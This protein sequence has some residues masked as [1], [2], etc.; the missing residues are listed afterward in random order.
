MK[1]TNHFN[2]A[3]EVVNAIVK[4]RYTVEGEAPSDYSVTDIINPI[5]VTILKKKYKDDLVQ[6]DVVDLFYSFLGSV[7]HQVLEDSTEG[8]DHTT[9][10]ERLYMKT[11]GVTISGKI[12]CYQ[13]ETKDRVAQIR[14]YKT[15]KVWNI[16]KG[17]HSKWEEQVNIYALLLREN[18]K[19]IEKL[20]ITCL[21]FDWKKQDTY[22][23]NYPNCPIIDIEIPLWTEKKQREYL[24]KKISDLEDA[25]NKTDTEIFSYYPCTEEDM[26]Q[27]FNGY[28][29]FKY[30]GKRAI[31]TFESNLEAI[32][33]LSNTKS[34]SSKTHYIEKRL[35]N[36]KRCFEHC[37]VANHCMQ[38]KTLC[39]NEGVEHTYPNHNIH[40][41]PL[42]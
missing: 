18:K 39:G 7:A 30:G 25:K 27:S 20:I 3:P 6:R 34:M 26:W 4:D 12:D 31:K 13:H 24:N 29:I 38:H 28:S 40:I 8:M 19:P 5:Q 36:R 33:H 21:L 11:N 2:L 37:D 9:A 15:T 23:E 1:Y 41:K 17:D 14:D 35:G 22:K 32:R 10:E 42:F 16:I